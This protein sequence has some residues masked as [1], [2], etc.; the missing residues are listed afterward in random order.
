MLRLPFCLQSSWL[1]SF[2]RRDRWPFADILCA[3]LRL[4][5]SVVGQMLIMLTPHYSRVFCS[6]YLHN[7]VWNS[8]CG[9][10]S[11]LLPIP[12]VRIRVKAP[13]PPLIPIIHSSHLNWTQRPLQA[14]RGPYLLVRFYLSKTQ[15]R[16]TLT[17][18]IFSWSCWMKGHPRCEW[19]PALWRQMN[20]FFLQ[21]RILLS[22]EATF[23]PLL[24]YVLSEF[25][26]FCR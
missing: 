10:F 21:E 22:S 8:H 19:F 23:L 6:P 13:K 16:I 11:F 26:R 7:F 20:W 9:T 15:L 14:R 25:N 18:W 24:Q 5:I 17:V 12:H 2:A 3:I 4:A 1:I